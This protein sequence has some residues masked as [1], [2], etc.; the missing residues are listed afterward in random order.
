MLL[1]PSL[2]GLLSIVL[3]SSLQ[4]RA[5]KYVLSKDFG[6]YWIPYATFRMTYVVGCSNSISTSTIRDLSFRGGM[7]GFQCVQ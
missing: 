6:I 1:K 2:I 5:N 4:K 7:S 3:K